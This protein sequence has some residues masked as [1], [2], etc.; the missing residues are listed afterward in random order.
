MKNTLIL[1]SLTIRFPSLSLSLPPP[2][3]SSQHFPPH[4]HLLLLLHHHPI[5]PSS[6]IALVPH[7]PPTSPPPCK[8]SNPSS[9]PSLPHLLPSPLPPFLIFISLFLASR[10][11]YR[12][13]FS[14]RKIFGVGDFKLKQLI[15]AS[16]SSME[17]SSV[18]GFTI[19]RF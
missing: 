19:S 13:L 5:S 1:W 17:V 12:G 2:P 7:P 16:F 15:F 10:P 11:W 18:H 3:L 14:T 8:N 9:A 4:R 6:I